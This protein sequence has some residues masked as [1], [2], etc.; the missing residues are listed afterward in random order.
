MCLVA[1]AAGDKVLLLGSLCSRSPNVLIDALFTGPGVID[2]PLH[3]NL[4][5]L[6][7]QPVDRFFDDPVQIV[8]PYSGHNKSVTLLV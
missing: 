3:N 2:V 4:G 7:F 8:S 1:E 5:R 6:H